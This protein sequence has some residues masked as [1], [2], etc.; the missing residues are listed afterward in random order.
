MTGVDTTSQMRQLLL[1]ARSM[2]MRAGFASGADD[3]GVAGFDMSCDTAELARELKQELVMWAGRPDRR[4]ACL[5]AARAVLLLR[6]HGERKWAAAFD[7][8]LHLLT[9]VEH[10]RSDPPSRSL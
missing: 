5:L 10:A 4:D 2:S 7:A 1:D 3:P 6:T 9:G 8:V